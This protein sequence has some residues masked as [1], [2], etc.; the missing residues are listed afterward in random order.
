VKSQVD[1]PT[2]SE[3]SSDIKRQVGK[4]NIS[5]SVSFDESDQYLMLLHTFADCW[6]EA[7][8]Q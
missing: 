1:C 6:G 3:M 7:V 5:V 2:T 4:I 8:T